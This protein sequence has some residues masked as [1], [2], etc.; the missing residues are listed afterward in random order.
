M[1]G[2]KVYIGPGLQL[3][4]IALIL[5]GWGVIQ[6]S[7]RKIATRSEDYSLY[8]RIVDELKCIELLGHAFWLGKD[9]VAVDV[10]ARVCSSK[11]QLVRAFSEELTS[12]GL[13]T[14]TNR[15]L[16]DLRKS[17]TLDADSKGRNNKVITHQRVKDITTVR[18]S[19]QKTLAQHL[20]VA[21]KPERK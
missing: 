20:L 12:R 11:M 21:H 16:V 15:Q 1:I 14:F 18:L 9:D 6:K 19:I 10:W 17:L 3:I 8:G 4:S 7:S 13:L 2:L 5:V